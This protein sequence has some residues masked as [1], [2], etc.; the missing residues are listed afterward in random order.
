M[1]FLSF[2]S[3]SERRFVHPRHHSRD[4][5]C[6]WTKAERGL[7]SLST[8]AQLHIGGKLC[9]FEDPIAALFALPVPVV[10][11]LELLYLIIGEKFQ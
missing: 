2:S 6:R 11:K 8:A 10:E 4:I 7:V 9:D 1:Y 5:G 3:L